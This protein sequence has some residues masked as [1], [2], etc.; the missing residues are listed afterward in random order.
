MSLKQLY[1]DHCKNKALEINDDQVNII[2]L[3][4][5]FYQENFSKSFFFVI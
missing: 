3:I 2:E 5:K 1:L 4:N